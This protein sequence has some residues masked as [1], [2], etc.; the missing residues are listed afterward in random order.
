ML[1]LILTDGKIRIGKN[2]AWFGSNK[3]ELTKDTNTVYTH[4]SSIQCN[5]SNEISNLK[6]SVSNGK[7]LIASA[8]T[9]KGVSTA[10]DATFQTMAN[11]I[12]SISSVGEIEKIYLQGLDDKLYTSYSAFDYEIN[13]LTVNG[14]DL[15]Q[16]YSDYSPNIYSLSLVDNTTSSYEFFYSRNSTADLNEW[17]CKFYYSRSA[18][19]FYADVGGVRNNYFDL[20]YDQYRDKE[21]YGTITYNGTNWDKQNHKLTATFTVTCTASN[22]AFDGANTI[23]TATITASI[24]NKVRVYIAST[25]YDIAL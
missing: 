16:I 21:T 2:K 23:K 10:S 5:A 1:Y 22:W 6:S 13:R 7:S 3:V 25:A 11:N 14:P 12:N 20:S 4:P 18:K 17:Y 15:Y 8:I 9:G 19:T 24:S